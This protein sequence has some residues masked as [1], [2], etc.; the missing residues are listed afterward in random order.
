MSLPTPLTRLIG[1]TTEVAA[2]QTIFAGEERR[3]VTVTGVGGTGKTRLAIAVAAGLVASYPD[4]V[5]F[6]DLSP[7]TGP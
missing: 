2:L 5:H 6:V 3:L 4:G 7:L 1:R